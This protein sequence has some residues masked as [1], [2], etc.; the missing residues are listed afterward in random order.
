MVSWSEAFTTE[1]KVKY[2]KWLASSTGI[3]NL[4]RR[5]EFECITLWTLYTKLTMKKKSYMIYLVPLN[6]FLQLRQF[7]LLLM[8]LTEKRWSENKE[9]KPNNKWAELHISSNS[10]TR[11]LKQM[12]YKS[13]PTK[14]WDG[15]SQLDSQI[16]LS[17]P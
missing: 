10:A 5:I 8:L 6:L 14:I 13:I 1:N 3:R 15:Q 4:F 7:Q 12:K 2:P 11:Y 9:V 17:V 16:F